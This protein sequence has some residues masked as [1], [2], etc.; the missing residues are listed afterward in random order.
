MRDIDEEKAMIEPEKTERKRDRERER[1]RE[2]ER[3][4]RTLLFNYGD[5]A[6]MSATLVTDPLS[7]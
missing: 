3:R 5:G 6:T 2:I 4:I 7:V 1:E